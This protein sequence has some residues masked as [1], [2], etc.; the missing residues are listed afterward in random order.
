V[1]LRKELSF[2]IYINGHPSD[3]QLTSITGLNLAGRTEYILT[4][5]SLD[6]DEI[7][8]NGKQLTVG[9]DAILPTYPIPGKTTSSTPIVLPTN[10]YGLIVFEANLPGC[11]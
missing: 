2:F 1:E 4:A 3:V 10:S 11:P 7:F 9:T 8:L 6:A 5:P